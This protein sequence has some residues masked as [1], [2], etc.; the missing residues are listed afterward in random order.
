MST[1]DEKLLE[2]AR[3]RWKQLVEA[4]QKQW[5]RERSDLAFYEGEGQWPQDIRNSRQGNSV[6]SPAGGANPSVPARPC[7]TINKVREPIRYVV[8]AIRQADLGVEIIPADD[9]AET[10]TID[11]GEIELREGLA[12][13]I[14]RESDATEARNWAADRAVKAGRGFYGLITQY[15]S[16]KSNDQEIKYRRFYDQSMVGLDPLHEAPD[17]SDAAWGFVTTKMSVEE[18]QAQYPKAHGNE[19]D[20]L[21]DLDDGVWSNMTTEYPDWF[22]NEDGKKIVFVREHWYTEYVPKTLYT[23]PGG[24][25]FWSDELPN[26]LDTD[27]WPSRRV[28][29]RVVKFI[30]IHGT[31][32]L[33]QTDWP[34]PFIPIFKTLGEEIQPYDAER[35]S[36][37]MI[38]PARDPQTSYNFMVSAMVETIALAPRAPHVGAAGQ[39]E[40][41]EGAWDSANVRNIGR[42]E[43]NPVVLTPDG[44][45]VQPGPPQRQVAEPPIQA[46][47]LAVQM[48]DQSVKSTTGIPDPTLGNVDPSIRSGKAIKTLLA[49]AQQGSSNYLDNVVVTARHEAIVL[50]SLLAPIYGNRIG[51]IVRMMN[52]EGETSLAMIGQPFVTDGE[53]KDA[54]PIPFDAA[55][56]QRNQAKEYKLTEDASWNVAVKVS[57]N[58]DTRRQEQQAQITDLVNNAPE[59]MIPVIGDLLFKYDDGPAARELSDRLKLILAPNVQ[60]ALDK[61]QQIPPEV[62]QQMGVLQQSVEQLQAQLAEASQIIQTKQVEQAAKIEQTKIETGSRERIAELNAATQLAIAKLKVDAEDT[63]TFSDALQ[64]EA[65]RELQLHMHNVDVAHQELAAARQGSEHDVEAE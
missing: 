50:N 19:S 14:Q 52:P 36:E 26:G 63:K 65:T 15:V 40:G 49:Q 51:R 7:L 37:G 58:Y 6:N 22:Q 27:G 3:K 59:A 31:K 62:Q 34:S 16:G 9:F 30:K 46:I 60:A 47:S 1:K 2:Q 28:V 8:N 41:F 12:R 11:H 23:A 45:A 53:G 32:I 48:F 44:Q 35:R 10:G 64:D 38:R 39:F 29:E 54:R 57:K 33:E 61:Q 24:Q 13:R 18:Y 56:H 20:T 21:F 17:G 42:L 43:Y 55:R 4:D 25:L 5:E